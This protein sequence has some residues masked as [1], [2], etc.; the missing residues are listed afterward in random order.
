MLVLDL[1]TALRRDVPGL[2]TRKLHLLLAEP[3]AQSGIKLGRDKLHKILHTHALIIRQG[4]QLP[5]TT[6]SNHRLQKYPNLLIDRP[7]TAPQQV[8]VSDITYLYIGLGF[9][10]LSLITD[11]YSKLIVGYCL[12]PFLTAEGSLKALD[13]ALAVHSER[14]QE[15]IHHSDRG[16]QYCS[17]EYVQKLKGANIMIS[18]TQQGDSYENTIA[19]RVNGILKTDFRLNRVFT[20]FEEAQKAVDKS[21]YNYNHLRPHMSCGYLTPVMAHQSE[22]PLKKHWKTKVYKRSKPIRDQG[23]F[24]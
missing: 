16:S 22:Q 2:G 21:I 10:Y 20:T 17:F 1:V 5:Q 4:R 23:Q 8:W 13:M 9:G 3:L 14:E 12:H 24:G 11:A 19:E 15:L 7:I 6:N 18:M